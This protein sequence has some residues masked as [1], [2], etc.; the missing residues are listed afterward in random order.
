[1]AD[2]PLA[3]PAQ[4]L[5]VLTSLPPLWPDENMR[6]AIR[7]EVLSRNETI[8]AIDDDPTGTQTVHHVPVLTTWAV[9]DLVAELERREPLFYILTNSRA[10]TERNAVALA[11]ELGTNLSTASHVVNRPVV[12]LSRSDST[13]RGHF[14]AET[15][16]LMS[17]WPRR[18]DGVLLAPYF[19]EGGRYTIADVHYVQDGLQL[20]PAA[21]TEFARD[22]VFG[23]HHSRLPEWVEEKSGGRWLAGQVLSLSIECI[24]GAGPE[25]VAARLQEVH[26]GRPVVVNAAHDRDLEVVVAGLLQAE[27][28]GKVFLARCA[29]SFVKVRAGISDQ[30]LLS[31]ARLLLGTN[32][33]GLIVVGSHVPRTTRQLRALLSMGGWRAIELN[34]ERVLD[35]ASAPAYIADLAAQ[36]EMALAAEGNVVLFTTRTLLTGET[37]AENLAIG[38]QVSSALVECVSTIR[39]RPRFLLAKGGI[40]SSDLATKAL[41]VR[42]AE[43]LGQIAPGVP[44]W[45]LG[46]E[47]RWPG[48][49]YII[50][51]GNVGSDETLAAVAASL[52][53]APTVPEQHSVST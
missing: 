15:D 4:P 20:L 26:D 38:E 23:Y 14:P 41:G 13:L 51:P 27:K 9:P 49:L 2:S 1:M 12:L 52:S 25:G 37:S 40:T 19:R 28:A 46:P 32:G 24:R 45:E 7:A 53:A 44:V 35:R 21:Q 3:D 43:V 16:A 42:R 34:V 18:P 50:F 31:P 30:G 47:S 8:V 17:A 6:P 36:V 48:L 33:G 22:P 10:L 5:S 11:R 29:A 39:T